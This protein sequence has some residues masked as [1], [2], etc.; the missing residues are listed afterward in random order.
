MELPMG[1]LL[2]GILPSY[3]PLQPAAHRAWLTGQHTDVRGRATTP[4]LVAIPPFDKPICDMSNREL[5]KVLSDF[6]VDR[7]DR[8]KFWWTGLTGKR[9]LATRKHE[10]IQAGISLGG[11]A[12]M[13]ELV[14]AVI[15]KGAPLPL[16]A[17]KDDAPSPTPTRHVSACRDH[18]RGQNGYA[19][20]PSEVRQLAGIGGCSGFL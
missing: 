8:I 4:R 20:E 16:P 17:C 13:V 1:L 6:G 10:L 7:I 3:T 12:L 19:A 11:A 2:L 18:C 14:E 9:F 5:R 15:T